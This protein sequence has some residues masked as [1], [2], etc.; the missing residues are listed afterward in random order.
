M[1]IWNGHLQPPSSSSTS[2]TS[3]I[4]PSSCP[5]SQQ[6]PS[7]GLLMGRAAPPA[8]QSRRRLC[9]WGCLF[10][11]NKR[12]RLDANR[13]DWCWSWVRRGEDVVSGLPNLFSPTMPSLMKRIK[14]NQLCSALRHLFSLSFSFVMTPLFFVVLY[15]SLPHLSPCLPRSISQSD[16][17]L[18]LC[19]FLPAPSLLH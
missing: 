11:R 13:T 16:N 18:F 17:G 7:N 6:R 10:T 2:S 15:P 4:S 5:Q 3:S 12:T 1:F 14:G 19:S 8:T 9:H